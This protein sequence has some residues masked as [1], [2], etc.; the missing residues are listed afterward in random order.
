MKVPNLILNGSSG[1][2]ANYDNNVSIS[3]ASNANPAI[4]LPVR[5]QSFASTPR[6]IE[7]TQQQQK[8][9]NQQQSNQFL[10]QSQSSARGLSNNNN[11]DKLQQSFYSSY[12]NNG[13]T[14]ER[15]HIKNQADTRLII[16][17]QHKHSNSFINNSS[18]SIVDESKSLL[19]EYEQLR[20]DSVSEIQRAHD[21][22]NASL[23]WL[24]NQKLNRMRTMLSSDQNGKSMSTSST[25][26]TKFAASNNSNGPASGHS[27]STTIRIK[28]EDLS[29]VSRFREDQKGA[30]R[31]TPDSAYKQ[32][33]TASTFQNSTIKNYSQQQQYFSKQQET[34]SNLFSPSQ[35]SHSNTPRSARTSFSKTQY[36]SVNSSHIMPKQE[37][38]TMPQECPSSSSSTVNAKYYSK[39]SNKF[40]TSFTTYDRAAKQI[41]SANFQIEYSDSDDDKIC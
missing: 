20:S 35:S 14:S 23:I 21:S 8:Q 7:Q 15:T 25:N 4:S 37:K 3:S 5:N 6:L 19:R 38:S 22:L 12:N 10:D 11:G 36:N 1:P 18:N 28:R 30:L 26:E 24:E 13:F 9:P 40:D 27:S 2:T 39:P 32:S 31:H 29:P 17:V 34:P 33:A 41:R 16:P